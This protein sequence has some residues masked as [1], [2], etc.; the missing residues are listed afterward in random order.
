MVNMKE[1][2]SSMCTYGN[3]DAK[4]DDEMNK[5]V[6]YLLTNLFILY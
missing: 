6:L 1:E 2:Q 3:S 4:S 5:K